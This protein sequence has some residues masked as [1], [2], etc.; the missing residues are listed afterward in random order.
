V[1][2]LKIDLDEGSNSNV[3]RNNFYGA[4]NYQLGRLIRHED[5]SQRDTFMF[6]WVCSYLWAI[7]SVLDYKQTMKGVDLK[8]KLRHSCLIGRKGMNK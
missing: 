4:V 5:L 6:Y 2:V 7:L 1:L 3:T 8:D